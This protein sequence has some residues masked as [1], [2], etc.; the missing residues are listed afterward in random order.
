M[1]FGV[2]DS[3]LSL[4]VFLVSRRIQD[5]GARRAGLLVVTIDIHHMDHH[6]GAGPPPRGR[7]EVVRLVDGMQ[8]DPAA[9]DTHLSVDDGP[10]WR[11]L[12][13]SRFETEYAHEEVVFGCD[14]R[15]R[16][17][18][19]DVD[20]LVAHQRIVGTSRRAPR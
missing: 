20:H 9:P 18:R 2:A 15:A 7:Q 14:V 13:A 11:S 16:E 17:E 19:Y 1:P 6:A 5:G 12:E 8:P 4:A 10:I 3:V